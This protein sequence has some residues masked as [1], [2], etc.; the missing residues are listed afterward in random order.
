MHYI[1]FLVFV[2][3]A[4]SLNAE[5]LSI[6][7]RCQ[8]L[9]ENYI[10]NSKEENQKDYSLIETESFYSKKVD[11]CIL[12]EK[13]IV[14]VEIHIRDLSKSIILDGGKNFNMLLHC[15][16]DGADSVIIDKVRSFKG[17]VFNVSYKE[18]LDDGFG[19]LPRTLKTPDK[20]F[21][22]KAVVRFQLTRLFNIFNSLFYIFTSPC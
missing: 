9:S 5:N 8:L 15:D 7:E 22:K 2:F 18:W 4:N 6:D 14:G 12:I 19:G 10:N 3:V 1:I 13:K 17:R 21:T 16:C 20:P 11:S